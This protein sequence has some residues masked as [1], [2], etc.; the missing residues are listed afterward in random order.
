MTGS[1]RS[2]T[3][4]VCTAWLADPTDSITSGAPTPSSSR[5]IRDIAS[6]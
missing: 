5:K 4:A 3:R 6:S 2:I 1:I